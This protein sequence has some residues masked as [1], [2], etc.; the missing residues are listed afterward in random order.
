[1]KIL[2]IVLGIFVLF[3]LVAVFMAMNKLKHFSNYKELYKGMK[4]EEV[5]RLLG[6]DFTSEDNK[7]F[8]RLTWT[9]SNKMQGVH[10]ITVDIKDG[11][12][13]NFATYR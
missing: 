9:M 2:L 1:M 4:E 5:I 12:V 8:K 3:S 7:K 11:V 13:S 6:K 10:K